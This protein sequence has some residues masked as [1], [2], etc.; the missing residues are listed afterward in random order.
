MACDVSPVAM[1]LVLLV[2]C[3]VFWECQLHF[4]LDFCICLF[5]AG[6]KPVQTKMDEFLENF[7]T[8]FD[9]P[10]P[11][12]FREKNVANFSRNSFKRTKICNKIFQIGNDPP[13]L[14][15]DI[16]FFPPLLGATGCQIVVAQPRAL[17]LS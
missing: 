15:Q 16:S 14:M 17:T 4:L 6:G 3:H 8:A 9:P 11:P 10:S 1:F 12:L 7:R 13:N 5:I 2:C